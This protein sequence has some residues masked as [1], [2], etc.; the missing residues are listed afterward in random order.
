MGNDSVLVKINRK[1][2]HHT[3]NIMMCNVMVF[4]CILWTLAAVQFEITSVV[5]PIGLSLFFT[6]MAIHNAWLLE[7]KL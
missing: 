2:W 7:E 3:K 4:F 6:I 1:T 5:W